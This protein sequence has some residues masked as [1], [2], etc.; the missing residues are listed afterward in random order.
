MNLTLVSGIGN[1]A[2]SLSGI[3]ANFSSNHF[4]LTNTLINSNSTIV[5][6]TVVPQL[7]ISGIGGNAAGTNSQSQFIDNDF[8]LSASA[9]IVNAIT[10]VIQGETMASG[11]GGNAFEAGVA[12]FLDNRFNLNNSFISTSSVMAPTDPSVDNLVTGIGGN[13][14]INARSLFLDDQFNIY[15]SVIMSTATVNGNLSS[16]LNAATAIG[17][18]ADNLSNADFGALGAVNTLFRIQDS[19]LI[20]KSIVYGNLANVV[21]FVPT[22]NLATG[23][24]GNTLPTGNSSA[25]FLSS[26]F[27][28][29][30]GTLD[31]SA[32]VNGNTTANTF[33]IATGLRADPGTFTYWESGAGIVRAIVSGTNLGTNEAFATAGTGVV[34]SLS[35]INTIEQP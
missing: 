25:H 5:I 21:L 15:H 31:V 8:D 12:S 9:I 24:G 18:N 14:S 29:D 27:Q 33:N 19:Q 10:G 32:T 7:L 11:I 30:G 34:I 2:A 6:Q 26:L 1:N 3:S 16:A 28:L 4:S 23:V 35:P 20:S 13:A 22:G 17:G